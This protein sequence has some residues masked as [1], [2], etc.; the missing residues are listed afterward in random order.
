VLKG[1]RARRS[2]TWQANPG[3]VWEE[4]EFWIA[5]VGVDPDGSLGVRK[6]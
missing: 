5:L 3:E 6:H 1:A 2:R 4:D